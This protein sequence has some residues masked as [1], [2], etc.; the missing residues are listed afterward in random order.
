MKTSGSMSSPTLK[1]SL[2]PLARTFVQGDLDVKGHH[3]QLLT[4]GVEQTELAAC[5][6]MQSSSSTFSHCCVHRSKSQ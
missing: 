5:S 6:A 4:I 2:Y 1:K 3:R